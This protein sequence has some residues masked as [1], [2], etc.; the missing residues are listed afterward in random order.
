MGDVDR[1]SDGAAVS[2]VDRAR[3]A[4]GAAGLVAT[5]AALLVQVD[6][7][8]VK[9]KDEPAKVRVLGI[10]VFERLPNGKQYILWFRIRD[11]RR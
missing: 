2:V 7:R 6:G 1:R 9:A 5:A 3:Q 8:P 11:V 10:P 4:A